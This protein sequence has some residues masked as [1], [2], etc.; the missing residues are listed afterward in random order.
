MELSVYTL[1]RELVDAIRVITRRQDMMGDLG[2]F[3][4]DAFDE[5][6]AHF[7]GNELPRPL[8]LWELTPYGR[9][10]G[11]CHILRPTFPRIALHP[12]LIH[13]PEPGTPL[14]S[15]A[16]WVM[17]HECIHLSNDFKGLRSRECH[18]D[19]PWID[20]VN[21]IGEMLWPGHIRAERQKM[22]RIDGRVTRGPCGNISRSDLASFPSFIPV[23]VRLAWMEQ[24]GI[25]CCG[26]LV[27]IEE[28]A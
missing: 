21:R 2:R 22:I 28:D 12:I 20:E 13:E 5:I 17:V 4:D 6:N 14:L 18:N 15:R 10:I 7:F 8:I 19:K 1:D 25:W 3:A 26:S 23:D 11:L 16:F 24:H 9:S 27:A